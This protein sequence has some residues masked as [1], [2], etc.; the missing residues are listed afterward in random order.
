MAV[1]KIIGVSASSIDKISGV[2][3]SS[4][5]NISGQEISAGASGGDI[6]VGYYSGDFSI[7]EDVDNSASLSSTDDCDFLAAD[8]SLQGFIDE[9]HSIS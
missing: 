7:K 4:A 3:K 6:T 2:S 8:L 1:D 9:V 5:D